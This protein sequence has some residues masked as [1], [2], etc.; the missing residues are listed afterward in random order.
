MVTPLYTKAVPP[1][2]SILVGSWQLKQNSPKR[3]VQ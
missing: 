3:Q 2:T 1:D